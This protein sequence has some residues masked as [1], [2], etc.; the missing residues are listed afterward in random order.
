MSDTENQTQTSETATPAGVPEANNRASE[1]PPVVEAAPTAAAPAEVAAEAPAEAAPAEA[2]P[3][4]AAPAEAAPAEAAPAEAADAPAADAALSDAEASGESSDADADDHSSAAPELPK[5]EMSFAEMFEMA[6]KEARKR[7]KDQ[8]VAASMRPG[9][10]VEATVVGFSH[11]SVFLDMGGKAEGVIARAD[12]LDEEGNLTVKEGDKVE[13]RIISTEGGQIRLGKVMGHESAKNRD[14]VKQAHE[15][16]IPVEGRVTGQNKGGLDVEVG[17]IRAFCPISQVDLRFCADPGQFIGQKLIFKVVEFKDRGRNVVVSRRMVLEEEQKKAADELIG[18]LSIGQRVIAKVTSLKDYGAFADVGGIEGLI[19]VS[20]LSHGR[21]NKPS[22]VLSVG[23]EVEVEI[24]RIEDDKKSGGKKISLS[25]KAL[26]ADPWD[27]AQAALRE[28]Q[29]VIG[30]VLRIQSFG[31]FVE[32][33]P[34]V[35]GL[36]HV[37]NMSNKRIGNPRELLKEGDEVEATVVTTD[38]KKKRIGLSLVKTPQ[39][40]AKELG[41]GQVYEGTVD[42]IEGFGLFVSLP[43]GARGLVP[44]SE[45]GTARGTDLAKEFKVGDTAKVTVLEA[46]KKSG[47]IRLSIKAAHAAEERAMFANYLDKSPSGKGLGTFGDLSML[48][49]LKD[50]L[51]KK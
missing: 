41:S 21:V 43:T 26:A 5:D 32:V 22:E 6:E 7:R 33:M 10:T 8:K 30:K 46:D 44:A 15:S 19:H 20:Q 37:S 2:A 28:G 9:K 24:I 49:A 27:E 42:R 11:D 17:G 45:T 38:W 4:E 18:K 29:K 13:A 34:G 36:I 50:Q 14:M 47:K 39:E 23:Q 35:D 16:G 40:L 1:T 31:A 12:L 3:A 51:E 25:M 48:Q